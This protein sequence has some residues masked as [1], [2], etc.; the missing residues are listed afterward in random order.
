MIHV[1]LL[2][3]DAPLMSFGGVVVDNLGVTWRWPG[4]S[5]LTGLFGNALG[6]EHADAERLTALQ[7]SLGYAARRDRTGEPFVDYQ[8][9]D[10]GQPFLMDTAWTSRGTPEDRAGASSETTHIRHRHYIAD[11]IFTVA[12]QLRAGTKVTLDDLE[13][14]MRTPARPLFLGRKS[15]LP[16]TPVL[17]G[18]TTARS[19]LAALEAVPRVPIGRGDPGLLAAYWPAEEDERADSRLIPVTDERDWTNQ[20]HVGRRSMR[21]GVIAPATSTDAGSA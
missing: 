12:V 1:L 21:E 8:T 15:C 20:I 6:Y 17:L 2:R 19:L 4:L 7:S 18:R 14:A 13:A 11:A 9:V 5:M 16:S 3:F 10:L